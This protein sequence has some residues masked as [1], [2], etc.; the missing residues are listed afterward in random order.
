MR[1]SPR[2]RAC[3]GRIFALAVRLRSVTMTHTFRTS[4]PSRSISTLTMHRMGLSTLSTSLAAFRARSRSC[5]GDLALPVG[6][7]DQEPVAGEVGTLP[8]VIPNFVG[9]LRVLAHHK[10]DGPFAG[11]REGFV[12]LAPSPDGHIEPLSVALYGGVAEL[13]GC[14]PRISP[15]SGVFTMPSATAWARG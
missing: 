10:E 5:L 15:I 4:H 2:P 9:G 12:E 8:E 1:R 3:S 13:H 14:A 6:V 7:D 11:R